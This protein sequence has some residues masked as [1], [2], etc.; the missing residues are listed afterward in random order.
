M[1]PDLKKDIDALVAKTMKKHDFKE[2]SQVM[3]QYLCASALIQTKLKVI[4][5]EV[6]DKKQKINV[7]ESMQFLASEVANLANGV[8]SLFPDFATNPVACAAVQKD[9]DTG[10][11]HIILF[12]F[13]GRDS[14]ERQELHV[15]VN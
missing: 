7:K 13:Y 15:A 1:N 3:L 8:S 12:H 5:A 10:M 9:I 2:P 6:V 11:E 14:K 4:G